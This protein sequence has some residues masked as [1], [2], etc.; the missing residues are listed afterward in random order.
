MFSNLS[1]EELRKI[2]ANPF[3][4]LRQ[5]EENFTVDHEPLV[6]E[7]QWIKAGVQVIKESGAEVFLRDLLENLK[8]NYVKHREPEEN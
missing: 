1:P 4:C 2:F 7:E 6:S 3:Y 8:G 5:V